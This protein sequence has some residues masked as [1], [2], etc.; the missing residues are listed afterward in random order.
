MGDHLKDV[1]EFLIP[2]DLLGLLSAARLIYK[3]LRKLEEVLSTPGVRELA[4]AA[5]AVAVGVVIARRRV[6]KQH[7]AQAT[8]R[9]SASLKVWGRD[10]RLK[11]EYEA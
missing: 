9:P 5:G 6:S 2:D 8:G 1:L 7:R 10:G 3:A 11:G 4:V